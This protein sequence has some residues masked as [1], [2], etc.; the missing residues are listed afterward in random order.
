MLTT[1]DS[2]HERKNVSST[3]EE[4]VKTFEAK[5]GPAFVLACFA[6]TA[7]HFCARQVEL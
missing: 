4:C 1:G 3:S 6:G 5:V 2:G 7:L